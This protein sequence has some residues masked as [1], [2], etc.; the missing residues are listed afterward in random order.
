[1]HR[2]HQGCR[3]LAGRYLAL[4]ILAAAALCSWVHAHRLNYTATEIVWQPDRRVLE[5]TH[6]VHLDDALP[7]LARLGALDGELDLPTTARLMV[8]MDERFGLATPH[9]DLALE[10]MGAHIDGDVL[11]V[12]RQSNRLTLPSALRI[13]CQLLQDLPTTQSAA[14]VNQV[15]WRVGDLVRSLACD[16]SKTHNQLRLSP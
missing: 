10:P 1:M 5:I 9:G 15:N 14:L 2:V 6:S 13:H 3:V 16:P 12:Y 4:L 11:Y 7:L 8:Y